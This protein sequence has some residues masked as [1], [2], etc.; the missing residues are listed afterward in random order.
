MDNPTLTQ[1]VKCHSAVQRLMMVSEEHNLSSWSRDTSYLFNAMFI[2]AIECVLMTP[3]PIAA[4]DPRDGP[5]L[6]F[7]GKQVLGVHVYDY[8]KK[9]WVVSADQTQSHITHGIPLHFI[10][11]PEV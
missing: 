5:V 2:K 3:R 9:M 4:I 7:R 1:L 8:A 6:G 10:P 11:T